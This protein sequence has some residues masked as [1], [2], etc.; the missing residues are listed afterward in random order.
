MVTSAALAMAATLPARTHGLGLITT[1]LLDDLG[2][3]DATGLARINLLATLLGSLCCL[4]C[5]WMIDRLGI[6][7][8]LLAVML[9]L[10]AAVWGTSQAE[11]PWVLAATVTL[12]RGLGQSMLSVVSITML[13]KWFTRNAGWAMGSYA[14]LMTVFMAGGTGL[15]AWRVSEVGWRAA[16]SDMGLGLLIMG[17]L[18]ALLAMRK[19]SSRLS[20]AGEAE[21][22]GPDRN[23][24]PSDSQFSAGLA[25][26]LRTGCFWLF[27]LGVSL[28]GLVSSGVSLFQQMIFAERGLPEVVY[29]RA[30]I[31]G[32]LCG[33]V[34]NL[35]GGWLSRR[36]S[37]SHLL[38]LALA[39]LAGS[40]AA[41]PLLRTAWQAY[42][43]AAVGGM[44]GGMIT[45]LF[46]AVWVHAY[47]PRHLGRIQGVAQMMTVL[48]SAV[49]PLVVASGQ[50]YFGSF[51]PVLGGLAAVAAGLAIAALT[52]AVPHAARGD[53][54]VRPAAQAARLTVSQE[55]AG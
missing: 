27:A 30:L 24:A 26:A 31:V 45:V 52:V 8:V 33:L 43:Q 36:H 42:L 4:P 18:A 9:G 35:A 51:F 37:M 22:V 5:G 34:A 7:P 21:L 11:T 16:W 13:G 49:G 20:L 12:S 44:A 25:A 41:L 48:A 32:L 29:H 28:F 2:G 54:F 14:V 47:G 53:W 1:R 46:F 55:S 10:A 38:A 17:P 3:L 50:D 6:R 15:L 40:L 19:R 39:V 23:P